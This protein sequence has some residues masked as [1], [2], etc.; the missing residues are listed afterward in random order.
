MKHKKQLRRK[1]AVTSNNGQ[2]KLNYKKFS[3]KSKESL[4]KVQR[5]FSLMK[6]LIKLFWVPSQ[7]LQ[8]A[9]AH[10]D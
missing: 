8:T 5:H 4:K 2:G 3:R 9:Q 7:T 10:N 6:Y 1:D